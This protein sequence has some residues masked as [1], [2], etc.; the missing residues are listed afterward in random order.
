MPDYLKNLLRSMMTISAKVVKDSISP[1][2]IR[3]TTL[4]IE[5]PRIIHAEMLTHRVFSHC[6]SASSRAIQVSKVIELVESNP[7]MHMHWGR[8]KRYAS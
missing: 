4:E 3:I 6:N 7:A 5:Y 8:I 1:Q 2:G